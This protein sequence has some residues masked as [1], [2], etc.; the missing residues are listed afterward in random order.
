[1]H[2]WSDLM[3]YSA[4]FVYNVRCVATSAHRSKFTKLPKYRLCDLETEF[5]VDLKRWRDQQNYGEKTNWDESHRCTQTPT[6]YSVACVLNIAC[7]SLTSYV[8]HFLRFYLLFV[9]YKSR[10][11][12]SASLAIRANNSSRHRSPTYERMNAPQ[13]PI[14]RNGRQRAWVCTNGWQCMLHKS[15]LYHALHLEIPVCV[16]IFRTHLS[17]LQNP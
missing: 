13:I 5:T 7:L 4:C 9:Q 16:Y 15:I 6:Q 11:N 1:M 3:H 8:S 14:W 2:I 10:W 17:S 12:I